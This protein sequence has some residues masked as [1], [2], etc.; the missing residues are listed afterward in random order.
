MRGYGSLGRIS[1]VAVHVHW[2]LAVLVVA[3]LAVGRDSLAAVAF[4]IA[5]AL[6]VILLHE[7]GHVLAIR[8]CGCRPYWI[9]LYPFVGVT[10]SEAPRSAFDAAC[11]AWG[12]VLAQLSVAIPLLAWLWAFG[13][14]SHGPVNA[15]LAIFGPLSCAWAVFNLLPLPPLD[16]AAA[17]R[18]IPV[19]WSRLRR[20][21]QA[22][23]FR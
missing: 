23:R 20:R 8:R 18:I 7:W 2:S 12:G 19:L 6:A 10:R 21:R 9:E 14:T 1:E 15:I 17:W 11:V 16:G 13:Y 3:A 4:L 5:C 22:R